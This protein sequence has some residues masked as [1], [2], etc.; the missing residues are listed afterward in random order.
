LVELVPSAL[1]DPNPFDAKSAPVVPEDCGRG[2]SVMADVDGLADVPPGEL[3][4]FS[5]ATSVPLF[6]ADLPSAPRPAPKKLSEGIWNSI[7]IFNQFI[8]DE[9][10]TK[11]IG[12]I[13]H[14]P[15]HILV[16]SHFED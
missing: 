16:S 9:C 4:A 6:G 7:R 11:F 3:V 15:S 10:S 13:I 2:F 8:M 14:F 5:D 12:C 1:V